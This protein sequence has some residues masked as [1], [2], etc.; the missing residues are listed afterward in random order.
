MSAPSEL[1]LRTL[2]TSYM[3]KD[4]GDFQRQAYDDL[5]SEWVP[6]LL[7]THLRIDTDYGSETFGIRVENVLA[8]RD[9]PLH[10][11]LQYNLRYGCIF[12]GDLILLRGAREVTRVPRMVLLSFPLLT[13]RTC[14][15][16]LD[17]QYQYPR[18]FVVNGKLRTIPCTLASASDE[19]LLY[20]TRERSVLEVRSLHLDKLFRS[21]STLEFSVPHR[22][23]RCVEVKIPFQKVRLDVG[24]LA[25]ALGCEPGQFVK[26]V[27]A[28]AGD[29]YDA[30]TFE[31][32]E[33]ALTR[34]AA[35]CATGDAARSAVSKLAGSSTLSTG[36]HIVHNEVFPHARDENDPDLQSVMKSVVLANVTA[37][38]ILYASELLER[39]F[40]SRS[41]ISSHTLVTGAEHLGALVRL[42]LIEQRNQLLKMLRRTLNETTDLNTLGS[43]HLP[44]LYNETRLSNRV[45]RALATGQWSLRRSGVSHQLNATNLWAVKAQDRRVSST[46]NPEGTHYDTRS[47]KD[48]QYGTLCAANGS[49]GETTGL[50]NELACTATAT[51]H[52]GAVAQRYFARLVTAALGDLFV[53]LP[54]FYA[55]PFALQS[56]AH[57]HAAFLLCPAAR[58]L[59]VCLDARAAVAAVRELR[60]SFTVSPFAGVAYERAFATVALLHRGGLLVRPLVVLR[61]A[62]G[63]P[64]PPTFDAALRAGAVEYVSKREE[65]SLCTIAVA[66]RYLESADPQ[67]YSHLELT[68]AAFLG[69]VAATVPFVTSQQGPRLSYWCN[70]IKQTVG[71]EPARAATNAPATKSLWYCHRP[72]VRSLVGSTQPLEGLFTPLVV[73]ILAQSDQGQ[74]DGMI[75]KRQAI[76]YGACAA[77]AQRAF[78]SEALPHNSAFGY[79]PDATHTS[80]ARY[81]HLHPKLGVPPRRTRLR[82]NDVVIAKTVKRARAGDLPTRYLDASTTIKAREQGV[83]SEACVKHTPTGTLVRV[84]V[85]E[86][87]P[88]GPGDKISTQHSQKGI[89]AR[90]EDAED[91]PFSADGTIPDLVISAQ[92]LVSRRTQA[93]LLEILTGKATALSADWDATLDDQKFGTNVRRHAR[94]M[95][96]LLRAH[97]F[98]SDGAERLY[99]GRTGLPIAGRV[100]MGVGHT[101]RL[102]HVAAAKVHARDTGPLNKTT[103]QAT[104]GR[105]NGGG[106]RVSHMEL[107]ALVAHGASA[108]LTERTK[109]LSDPFLL[110]VCN[111]CQLPVD[112]AHTALGYYFCDRCATHEH[113]RRVDVAFN[114]HKLTQELLATHIDVRRTLRDDAPTLAFAPA[115]QAA[116]APA[117]PEPIQPLQQRSPP[118][119]PHY[120][121]PHSPHYS[122]P[123]S[124][125]YSPP[126][127]SPQIPGT[128]LAS[129][130]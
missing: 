76:Q 38:L 103:R 102:T 99:D 130:L 95:G 20:S 54:R 121:P 86:A 26:L 27:R 90:V 89:V 8:A 31:P 128:E 77:S 93:T 6:E 82:E 108:V 53:P 19:P 18:C 111:R 41:D 7:R 85:D 34:A 78:T 17:G 68:E 80:T 56:A 3:Y 112:S 120:S 36:E 115:Q 62:G 106:L 55:A 11:C 92:S 79:Q 124:P 126:L 83:V 75:V 81:A 16:P 52:V 123:H 66:P 117:P 67:A 13:G 64:M 71:C 109:T 74:E 110:H 65:I 47:V 28:A 48:D 51:P 101:A 88:L 100:F 61:A 33:L 50:T 94:A 84:T 116:A 70:Q 97:G 96:D 118:H 44:K 125:H 12:S 4:T 45:W 46:L 122:P 39:P 60:R 127:H 9:Q 5:L 87:I 113:V 73:A 43:F 24:V 40:R 72:L 69:I 49:G 42:A 25:L 63:Q 2:F 22:G 91:L 104:C 29:R 114:F 14:L 1:E 58:P 10:R 98:A 119:S 59:G 21:T 32:F 37:T 57:P 30:F 23:A 105:R 15:S 107:N 35:D 129:T